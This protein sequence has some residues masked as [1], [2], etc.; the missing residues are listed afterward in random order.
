MKEIKTPKEMIKELLEKGELTMQE[1]AKEIGV[2]PS[3]ITRWL[4]S[5]EPKWTHFRKIEEIY[6]EKITKKGI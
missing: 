1:L 5:A 6:T 2:A 3:Q 4:G